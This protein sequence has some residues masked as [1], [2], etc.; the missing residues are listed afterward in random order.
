[1]STCANK[2]KS[3][4]TKQYFSQVGTSSFNSV[5]S[6]RR[7]ASS[8]V[9]IIP[10]KERLEPTVSTLDEEPL[11][12]SESSATHSEQTWQTS[13]IDTAVQLSSHAPASPLSN[14]ASNIML[15]SFQE[16][17]PVKELTT[18]ARPILLI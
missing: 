7:S 2:V 1:E 8:V 6:H 3:E 9:D 17:P 10:D 11:S 14:D 4:D 18:E 16:T 5:P 13:S 15:D 12:V